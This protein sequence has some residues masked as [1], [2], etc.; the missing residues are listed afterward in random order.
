M[1]EQ[2]NDST[3]SAEK[4]GMPLKTL[5]VLAAVVVIEAVVICGA[6]YLSGPPQAAVG[7]DLNSADALDESELLCEV[8][9]VADK[10][11][12]TQSGVA[13]QY[14]TEVYI[15]IARKHEDEVT[16]GIEAM[17]K[18]IET[19]I[20]TLFRKAQPAQLEEPELSTMTRKINSLLDEYIGYDN[21]EPI[22]QKVLIRKCDRFRVDI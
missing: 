11:Q 9:V 10:F 22:V 7:A 2:K 6:F 17:Q 18:Q 19:D 15:V 12:N 16:T 8:L 14:D 13:H 3:D 4:K 20:A 5:M 1:V 21:G